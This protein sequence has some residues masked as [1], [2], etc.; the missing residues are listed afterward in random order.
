MDWQVFNILEEESTLV[1]VVST[2]GPH[3]PRHTPSPP[4]LVSSSPPHSD[5]DS[6]SGGQGWGGSSAR[7]EPGHNS[8][9]SDAREGEECD[10][11]SVM[12]PDPVVCVF[13]R[14]HEGT[15]AN[16][17]FTLNPTQMVQAL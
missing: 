16:K 14:P 17:P 15:R 6:S 3:F 8:T 10:S 4:H 7:V 12:E 13:L 11:H 1:D 2:I 9:T 5:K